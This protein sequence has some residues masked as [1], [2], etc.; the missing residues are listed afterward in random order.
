VKTMVE[1]MRAAPGVGLAA[2]QIG[3]PLRVA[4]LEDPPSHMERLT[5]DE[6]RDRGRSPLPLTVLVNPELSVVGEERATFFEGCL[7][8][9]GYMALVERH[10]RVQVRAVDA[11]GAKVEIELAGWPA[12]IAQHELDHLAGTL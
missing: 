8:V 1:V 2:P 9:G 12:R 10:L 5:D 7:S 11:N 6:K 4:V 3:V